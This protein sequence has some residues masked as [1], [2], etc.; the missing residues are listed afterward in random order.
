MFE[1]LLNERKGR[2][3]QILA[4]HSTCSF[5]AKLLVL[6]L[7][8]WSFEPTSR[9]ILC[10]GHSNQHPKILH[11]TA[12][13]SFH[14]QLLIDKFH[15][16]AHLK[17]AKKQKV[18]KSSFSYRLQMDFV[19]DLLILLIACPSNGDQVQLLK[20]ARNAFNYVGGLL[21]KNS[22]LKSYFGSTA[23]FQFYLN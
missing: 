8:P 5:Q 17:C 14:M 22:S 20:I 2:T 6:I 21:V 13:A 4:R 1:L 19:H 12:K 9:N 23:Q 3:G 7:C 11:K 15:T 16:S 10:H 18:R